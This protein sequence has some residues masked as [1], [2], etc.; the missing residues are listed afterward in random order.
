MRVGPFQQ[1]GERVIT[2]IV[3]APLAVPGCPAA[4][5]RFRTQGTV[6]IVGQ[7]PVTLDIG[8]RSATCLTVAGYPPLSHIPT[9]TGAPDGSC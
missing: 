3:G 8:A 4:T 6:A 1:S 7:Y 2:P 5:G 9:A